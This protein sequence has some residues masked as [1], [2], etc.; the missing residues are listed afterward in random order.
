MKGADISHY[1]QGLTI[2]QIRDDGSEF[3]IIKLTE[4]TYLVDSSAFAF[5]REAYEMRF[6]VGCY[7]YSHA[8]TA[9]QAREEAA[10]LLKTL[11]GFPMPCGIFL[12]IEEP[13]QL[14]LSHDALLAVMEAWCGAIRQAG[15]MPGVYSSEGTLWAKVHPDELQGALIWIAHYGKEPEL[16]CDL[17][18]SSDSGHVDGYSGNVDT[19]E[20]R[21]AW[22]ASLV[23]KGFKA[24]EP[25]KPPDD[26]D[27]INNQTIE[28]LIAFLRSDE[29][30]AAFKAWEG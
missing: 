15:Y 10:F 20:T 16:P 2:R 23:L 6:P 30:K 3:V 8:T 22:F 7:C 28:K 25:D 19:D 21:S 11:N 24:R 18:Q 26:A 14:A 17:W 12:D 29:F 13:K 9:A 5:Y 4:G 1:Q 27:Q